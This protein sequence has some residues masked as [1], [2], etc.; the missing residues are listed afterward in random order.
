MHKHF[1]LEALAQA[2]LGR[3]FCAP[4]PSVGAVAVCNGKIIAKAFHRGAGTPHAEILILDQISAASLDNV[5]LYVTL[6]P[7]NHWGRTPPCVDAIIKHGLHHIVYGYTDPNPAVKANNTPALLKAQGIKAEYFPLPE[8]NAFYESYYYWRQTGKPFVTAKIAHSLDGKIAYAKGRTAKI[9]NSP[10]QDFTHQQ[11]LKTDV[12]LTSAKTINQDNPWLN[13]RLEDKS[14]AKA[15]AI[16]DTHLQ[17]NP[18]ARIFTSAKC[19]HF[20]YKEPRKQP[21]IEHPNITYHAVATNKNGL[22]L[23]TVLN[24]LGKLGYHDV[25]VEAGGLIFTALHQENLV[26]RTYIYL[27]PKIL[28]PEAINAYANDFFI[29]PNSLNWTCVGDNIIGRIDWRK[30]SCLPV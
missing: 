1:L 15:I 5:I 11:R 4:N 18:Q 24:H 10:C 8:I 3:G 14:Y 29:P 9:S 6:E 7:C 27:A 30:P 16:L 21:F 20:Y 2:K 25:W 22:Q 26:D 17:V 23:D 12:I 19:C 28:G 13:V